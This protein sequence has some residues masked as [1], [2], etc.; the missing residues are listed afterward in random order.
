M[1]TYIVPLKVLPILTIDD[2][3]AFEVVKCHAGTFDEA[4]KC[5][6][7]ISQLIHPFLHFFCAHSVEGFTHALKGHLTQYEIE[8][9]WVLKRNKW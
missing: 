5:E 2:E 4:L 8:V 7:P 9:F 3:G 6:E 1:R